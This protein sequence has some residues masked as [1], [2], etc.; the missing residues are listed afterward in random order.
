MIARQQDCQTCFP[1]ELY[2][3]TDALYLGP[4]CKQP[5]PVDEQ[6]ITQ[7]DW[8]QQYHAP[9]APRA[10]AAMATSSLGVLTGAIRRHVHPMMVS[11]PEMAPTARPGQP[12][13]P[14]NASVSPQKST[15]TMKRQASPQIRGPRP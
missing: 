3:P 7:T 9:A 15:Q 13:S 5:E 14:R 4:D 12:P 2:C 6:A 1:C 8:P 11:R 10:V